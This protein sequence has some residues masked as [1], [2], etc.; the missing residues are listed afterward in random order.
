MKDFHENFSQEMFGKLIMAF[1]V[2]SMDKP[3]I[4]LLKPNDFV[5]RKFILN[6][7]KKETLH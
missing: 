7:A 3:N 6:T 4:E 5:L 1:N 2:I